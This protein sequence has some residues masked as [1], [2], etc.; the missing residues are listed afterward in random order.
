MSFAVLALPQ[1]LA[2][3]AIGEPASFF[4]AAP[5]LS[6]FFVDESAVGDVIKVVVFNDVRRDIIVSDA[7]YSSR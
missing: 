7:V 2:Q 6:Y 4:E 5:C 3:A 1:E